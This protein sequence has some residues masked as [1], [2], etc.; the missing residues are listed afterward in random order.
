M[1]LGSHSAVKADHCTSILISREPHHSGG[2]QYQSRRSEKHLSP[3][4]YVS[5]LVRAAFPELESLHVQ[6]NQGWG[7]RLRDKGGEIPG[8]LGRI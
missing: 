5:S 7:P 6:A 1:C 8:D 4:D 3:K 2:F